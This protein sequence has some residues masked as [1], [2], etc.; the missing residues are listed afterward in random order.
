MSQTAVEELEN[1]LDWPEMGREVGVYAGRDRIVVA[2]RFVHVQMMADRLLQPGEC[3]V[4]EERWRHRKIPQRSRSKFVTVRLSARDL[5]QAEVLVM[6]WPVE[7]DIS[8]AYAEPG[9]DLRYSDNPIAEIREHFIG[10]ASHCV[11]LLATGFP[12][13]QQCSAL[14]GIGHRGALPP[15]EAVDRRVCERERELEFGD[16]EPEHIEVDRLAARDRREQLA[17]QPPVRRRRV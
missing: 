10:I 2:R 17:E 5:F 1:R 4:V 13:E 9:S 7:D 14:L 12:E 11:A 8:R 15:S 3:S 16:G 6:T